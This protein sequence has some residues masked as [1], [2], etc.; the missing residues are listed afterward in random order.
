MKVKFESRFAKDLDN[1]LDVK[2]LA[3]IKA[4]VIECQAANNLT[5]LKNIK[6]LQGYDTYYRIRLGDYRLGLE[7]VND[8]II[9]SRFLHRKDVYK[10]FP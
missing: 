1:I 4:V 2:L 3:K 8:E 7:V 10:Y 6:K 9:F 5:E